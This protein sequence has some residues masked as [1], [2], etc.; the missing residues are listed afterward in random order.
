M[1]RHGT[2]LGLWGLDY[3]ALEAALALPD[4]QHPALHSSCCSVGV[5]IAAGDAGKRQ[6]SSSNFVD[7]RY[8]CK[9]K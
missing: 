8:S 4:V 2:P 9:I 1:H 6:L 7:A 3:E 5:Y